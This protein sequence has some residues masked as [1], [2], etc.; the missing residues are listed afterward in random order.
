MLLICNYNG[1]LVGSIRPGRNVG[2]TFTPDGCQGASGGKVG[3]G[4][5]RRL[6]MQGF[7]GVSIRSIFSVVVNDI[8]FLERSTVPGESERARRVFPFY[9]PFRG[10]AYPISLVEF[11]MTAEFVFK[12]AHECGRYLS[13]RHISYKM[14][15][16]MKITQE[17]GY[18][19]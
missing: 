8:R 1:D 3:H 15:I 14:I 12:I 4:D 9:R 5:L 19:M 18:F 11:P 2:M 6:L 16:L 17:N 7:N 10:G 13:V